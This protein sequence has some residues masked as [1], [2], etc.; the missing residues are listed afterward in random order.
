MKVNIKKEGKNKEYNIISSW[1]D[2]TLEKW[3]Q[4]ASATKNAKGKGA[5]A[6]A[7][8]TNLSDLPA[9]MLRELSLSDVAKLMA[10]L[11][12]IQ[13]RANTK[14]VN[15]IT[16]NGKHYGFLPDLEEITLGEWADLEHCIEQGLQ[17]NLHKLAAILYRPIVETKGN[18][19]SIEAYDVAS[20]RVREQEF[21]AMPAAQVESAM[22]FFWTFVSELLKILPLFLTQKLKQ[23]TT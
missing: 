18:W 14:L 23:A 7:T 19:Y 4:L 22:L 16:L 8:I 13:S 20:K 2:V 15:K 1:E 6:I 10:K 12:D 3:A 17:E 21:K 9:E 5:E 11:A